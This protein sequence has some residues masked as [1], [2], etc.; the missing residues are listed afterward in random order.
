MTAIR[1][2]IDDAYQNILASGEVTAPIYMHEAFCQMAL[3]YEATSERVW[4]QR[5]GDLA[6]RIEAGS[7][8]DPKMPSGWRDIPLPQGKK[9]RLLL[10]HLSTEAMRGG[11]ETVDVGDSLTRFAY[12]LGMDANGRNLNDLRTQI[13]SLSQA[14]V[15][16]SVGGTAEMANVLALWPERRITK[17][18]GRVRLDPAFVRSLLTTA[19]PLDRR[20]MHALQNSVQ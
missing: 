3:P 19:V 11:Q 8:P 4:Q 17:W 15:K 20:I 6:L 16:L 1:R 10:A 5:A 14:T 18:P 12:S 9:V 13:T 7:V 2:R